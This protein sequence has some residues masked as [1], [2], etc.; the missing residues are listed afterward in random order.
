M[1]YGKLMFKLVLIVSKRV[2]KVKYLNTLPDSFVKLCTLA[3]TLLPQG[4]LTSLMVADPCADWITLEN[5]IDI[6]NIY[7]LATIAEQKIIKINAEFDIQS[8]A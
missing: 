6:E 8:N 7:T 5:D 1:A 3:Q 2:F 4:N